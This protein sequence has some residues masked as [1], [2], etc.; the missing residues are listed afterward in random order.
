MRILSA[1]VKIKN[2]EKSY[3]VIVRS[4]HGPLLEENTSYG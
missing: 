4:L 3:R 1:L 2:E